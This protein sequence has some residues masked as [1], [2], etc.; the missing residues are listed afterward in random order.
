MGGGGGGGGGGVDIVHT[1]SVGLMPHAHDLIL[2][3]LHGSNKLRHLSWLHALEFV[4]KE[5]VV[6]IA[7]DALHMFSDWPIKAHART[8]HEFRRG[9][10]ICMH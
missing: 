9:Y 10:S 7:K 1:F 6:S 2:R 4:S 8:L 3:L 5:L